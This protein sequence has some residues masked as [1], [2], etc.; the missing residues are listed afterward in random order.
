MAYLISAQ[1]VVILMYSLFTYF[2][3]EKIVLTDCESFISFTPMY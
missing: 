3:E 1:E 2:H